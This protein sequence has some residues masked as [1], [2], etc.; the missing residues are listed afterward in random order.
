MDPRPSFP[1]DQTFVPPAERGI[2]TK[3][4]GEAGMAGVGRRGFAAAARAAMFVGLP[5]GPQP[6]YG[7]RMNSN[8]GPRYLDID[9]AS[10]C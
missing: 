9:A 2:D 7:R 6:L 4:G 8:A 5:Q 3:S 10:R 1:P